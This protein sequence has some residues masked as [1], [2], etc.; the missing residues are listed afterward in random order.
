[1]QFSRICGSS[2]VS[3]RKGRGHKEPLNTSWG[4]ILIPSLAPSSNR[5]ISPSPDAAMASSSA[6]MVSTP[7]NSMGTS[8]SRTCRRSRARSCHGIWGAKSD[9]RRCSRCSG[10]RGVPSSGAGA[11]FAFPTNPKSCCALWVSCCHWSQ[12][13]GSRSFAVSRSQWH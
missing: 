6:V 9:R 2:G 8:T 4:E 13:P 7:F 10:M 1:M 11:V 5:N 12:R 3:H